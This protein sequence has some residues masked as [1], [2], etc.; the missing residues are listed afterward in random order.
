MSQVAELVALQEIDA[1]S[2]AA[3]AALAD[4]EARL[5]GDAE[6]D[7]ARRQLIQAEAERATIVATQRRLE[8]EVERLNDRIAP[9]EKRL[10][11]GSVRNPKELTGI[12]HELE[13]LKAARERQEDALV[14][15]LDQ[16]E[17]AS[18]QRS[19]AQGAVTRLEERWSRTQEELRLEARR[20]GD[21]IARIDQRREAQAARI[22]PRLLVTY[23]DL[24]RRKGG[25][26]VARIKGNTCSGCRITIPDAL[27]SRVLA[28]E[29]VAQ[30][31]NCER[32][33]HP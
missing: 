12:Q 2:A 18:R 11:D 31:P 15:V 14:E 13:L 17:T 16:A 26:A 7:E 20:L 8:D 23:E 19:E 25:T 32:I 22:P 29:T 9:E 33:F 27:R 24:R 30:C 4:V 10:Y 28:G 21:A 5:Q 1:E 3:R 6:L